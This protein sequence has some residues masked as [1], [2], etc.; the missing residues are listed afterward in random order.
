MKKAFSRLGHR[1]RSTA[2]RG[3]AYRLLA[4]VLM[5]CTLSP[6]CFS[7]QATG[8]LIVFSDVDITSWY[9]IPVSY[10][11]S[12]RIAVGYNGLFRPTASVSRGEFVVMLLATVSGSVNPDE[13]PEN[14]FEDVAEGT[15]YQNAVLWAYTNGITSGTGST[16]FSPDDSIQRQDMALMILKAQQLAELGELPE[17][18]EE[19]AFQDEDQ[20]SDYAKEAVKKLQRQG[21]LAGDGSGNCMPHG[22][23]TRA[24]AVTVL[25]RIHTFKTGHTHSFAAAELRSPTCTEVGMQYYR[26]DCGSYY[27]NQIPAT[28]HN[29]TAAEYQAPTCTAEGAQYYRCPCGSFYT[30]KVPALGH[31]YAA[32][33]S[34]APNCTEAGT[35]YYRCHCGSFYTVEVP[36]L[37]HNWVSQKDISNWRWHYTCSRCNAK[38]SES[39]RY[40]KTYD[41]N[42][43]ISNAQ[44]L[45]AIDRLHNVYPDL[46]S[47]YVGGYSVQGR[48]IRVAKLG[49][50]SRYIFM[51]ANIHGLETVTTNYLLEVMDEYAYAYATDGS[52]GGYRVRPLLD[53][54]TIVMIPC[55]NPD[56]RDATVAGNERST[57]ARGVNLNENF[58][59]NWSYDSSGES[60]AYAGSEPETQVIMNTLSA[61]PCE[62]VIDCHT[63][64]N[65]IYYADTDCSNA[66]TQQSYNIASAISAVNGFGLYTYWPSAGMANYA[67]HPYGVPG[68]TVEMYPYTAGSIDCSKFSAYCWSKLDSMPAIVMNYL[69]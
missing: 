40:E 12:H 23:L 61:F 19:W 16:T 63:S 21:L 59:T 65:V 44:C 41:G 35:Q 3:R 58:P 25:M 26:C 45:A 51:N 57:N 15:Y 4:F 52:F 66:L 48:E 34:Q 10:A 29:Y 5:L 20:I 50:G 22:T 54:F 46:I 9:A 53:T 27:G 18:I 7:A 32:A 64:G 43:L 30:V 39:M 6:L 47:S 69:K 67:R 2:A 56:A 62:L 68:L 8:D 33:E 17:T 60:G 49:R 1:A 11:A 36:A 42:S 13:L 24:E 28:G 14:P 31:S 37:G 38:F 55:S